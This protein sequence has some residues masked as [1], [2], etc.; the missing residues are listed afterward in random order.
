MKNE[1]NTKLIT[2]LQQWKKALDDEKKYHLDLMTDVAKYLLPQFEIGLVYG[3]NK[4]SDIRTGKDCYDGAAQN[5]HNLLTAGMF[6]YSMNPGSRWLEMEAYKPGYT[7]SRRIRIF[8][9]DLEEA[10]YY[11]LDKSNFY[12]E[13]EKAISMCAGIGTVPLSVDEDHAGEKLKYKVKHPHN[14]AIGG[15]E[16]GPDVEF[17]EEDMI[18]KNIWKEY[19]EDVFTPEMKK[20]LEEN[21]FDKRKV[22]VAI[23]EREDWQPGY[24]QAT[25]KRWASVHYLSEDNGKDGKLL[26]ISGYDSFPHLYWRWRTDFDYTW[27][28]SLGMD[29]LTD[30]IYTSK[31][32]KTSMVQAE[33]MGD[34][35]WAV[36]ESMKGKT[37][38]KPRG[39]H[40]FRDRLHIPSAMVTGVNWIPTE[41]TIERKDQLLRDRYMV[42]F[43]T[44][45]MES[46][47]QKT[48][49]EIAEAKSEQVAV[50]S[51]T[52]IIMTNY[53]KEV[54]QR[55][56]DIADRYG[57]MPT[58]PDEMEDVGVRLRFIGPLPRAR[59]MLQEQGL[60]RT[61]QVTGELMQTIPGMDQAADYLDKDEV[62][63][64]LYRYQSVPGKVV[65]EDNEV[66]IIRQLR[67]RIMQEERQAMLAQQQAQAYNN[68]NQAP[69][70][71]APVG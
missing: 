13:M 10:L 22:T 28:T 49:Y 45:L 3:F 34:P 31:M 39:M 29:A 42:G 68:A 67:A 54:L 32:N 41:K 56:Y 71:G 61:L 70:P 57:R 62:M 53:M 65:K 15:G 47:R 11:E 2:L 60:L 16:E 14:I 5:Y 18:L 48:A 27:G 19:G 30:I 25:K 35:P 20:A 51:P 69:V 43:F 59:Q 17:F 1:D 7:P 4:P 66:R 36:H 33:L 23:Y 58:A 40:Y 12:T 6:G 64:H 46:N 55:T 37:R 26:R 21:P 52:L 24:V 50:L 44:M 63:K 9:D 8:L 38:I